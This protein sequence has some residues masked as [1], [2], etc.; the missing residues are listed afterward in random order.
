MPDANIQVDGD[1]SFILGANSFMSPTKL[2]AGQYVMGMNVTNRG[3]VAQTR[4][5]SKSLF[6]VDGVNLQGIT[7]FQPTSGPI[8]LVFVSDGKVYRSIYPFREAAVIPNLQF[9]KYSKYIAW[10]KCV[11]STDYDDNGNLIIRDTPRAILII[12]DGCTRAAYWDGSTGAHLNPT[13]STTERTYAD[14][15]GTPVGLWMAWSNNRL[16]LSTGNKVMA[17][18]IGNP[19]KFTETQYLNEGRAFYL[20]GPC[21]GIVETTD[22]SGIICFTENNG[23][24]I[25]SSIQNRS[26]WLAT[27]EFCKTIL[28]FTGCIAPRSIVNQYGII[29]WYTQRGL[30]NMDEA[31]RLYISSRLDVQDQEMSQSKSNVDKNLSGVAGGVY[32]NFL[33]HAV[34]HGDKYNTRLH[35]LDQAT[36]DS[37]RIN[38]WPSYWEGWRP[39]EI[40]SGMVMNQERCFC[41]S[42]DYDG[43]NRIWELFRPEKTDNGIPITC[44]IETRIHFFGNRDRKKFRYAEAELVDVQGDVACMIAIAGVRGAFQKMAEKD[45]SSTIG[46]IY[47][48]VQYGVDANDLFGSRS[49]TRIVRTIDTS[50]PSNGNDSCVETESSRGL[51]DRGFSLL[52]AWSGIAGLSAYRIFAESD[53]EAYQGLCESQET[54]E[55]RLLTI[56]GCGSRELVSNARAFDRYYATAT[57]SRINKTTGLPV[58][59][60]ATQSS[61]ISQADAN[62]K[63]SAIATWKVLEEI[64]ELV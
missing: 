50:E 61:I 24:L 17:S 39:I 1:D 44:S 47:Y 46:Q 59:H 2:A 29:W 23:M 52:I 5:G 54:G 26:L 58:I 48:T 3:G 9:G 28:P 63:A 13:K 38:S 20:S 10:A 64:G 35:V 12:Q 62:R 56:D 55:Y 22:Q 37:G 32:E 16:W 30:I 31:M 21:T 41:L 27:P 6:E 14:T 25:K 15:D 34:P 7:L 4:P 40:A 42:A 18:D 51:Q 19:L 8:Q 53:P 49:Q 43:K 33:F 60:S 36:D 11:Q 45:I 57:L